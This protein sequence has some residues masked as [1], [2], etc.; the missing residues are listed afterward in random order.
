MVYFTDIRPTRHYL[1]E[2]EHT[3][4][5]HEV[6]EIILTTKHPRK[7]KD[8]FEIKKNNY[9]VVFTIKKTVLYVIN[10]KQQR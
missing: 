8:V 3:V 5:W 2:H 1:E 7:K 6:I 4:P 9:Y 10:A